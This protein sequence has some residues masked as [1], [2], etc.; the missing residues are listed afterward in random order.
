ML[1]CIIVTFATATPEVTT[2]KRFL[3][4]LDRLA[5]ASPYAALRIFQL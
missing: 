2:M 3:A 1:Q 5:L 4:W